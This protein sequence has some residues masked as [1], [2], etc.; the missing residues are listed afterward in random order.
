MFSWANMAGPV[1]NDPKEWNQ[2]QWK[3][4]GHVFQFIYGRTF[5]WSYKK[6]K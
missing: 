5:S 4:Y 2:D 6:M 1:L 3:L